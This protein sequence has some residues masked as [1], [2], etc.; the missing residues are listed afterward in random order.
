MPRQRNGRTFVGRLAFG[1]NPLWV[2][3]RRVGRAF[4]GRMASGPNPFRALRLGRLAKCVGPRPKVPIMPP[5]SCRGGRS[6]QVGKKNKI[7]TVILWGTVPLMLLNFQR[8]ICNFFVTT[9]DAIGSFV[10]ILRFRSSYK[11][12]VGEEIGYLTGYPRSIVGL[13]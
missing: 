13:G 3:G 12:R 9:L 10:S 1:P 2:P 11:R 5:F 8:K 4:L 6:S 7:L